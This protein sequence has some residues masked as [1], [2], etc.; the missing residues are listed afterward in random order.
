MKI[1]LSLYKKILIITLDFS[2]RVLKI[3]SR[4]PVKHL[5]KKTSFILILVSPD[6]VH[7]VGTFRGFWGIACFVQVQVKPP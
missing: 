2:H 1:I 7:E 6:F 3:S 5:K 4:L